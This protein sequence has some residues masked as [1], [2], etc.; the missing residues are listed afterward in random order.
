[1]KSKAANRSAVVSMS[2]PM[3]GV[4][5]NRIRRGR[6][7]AEGPVGLGAGCLLML[8]ADRDVFWEDL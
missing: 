4:M 2:V 6:S 3:C 5:L 8:G 7:A 1:M